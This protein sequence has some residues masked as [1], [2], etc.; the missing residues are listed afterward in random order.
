MHQK[1]LY[2]IDE[3]ALL[4]KK[5]KRLL[6]IT[7]AGISAEAG[8]PTYRGIGGVYAEDNT[9]DGY[10]IEVAVSGSMLAS[11]PEITWKYL[12]KV[13]AACRGAKPS[14]SHQILAQLESKY[15]VIILTQNVDGLH[16]VAGSRNVID[17]HG[18]FRDLLCTKC[19]E[20]NRVETYEH[21]KVPPL[22]HC[23]GR[24]RPEVVL[25]GEM[26]PI[27]K[28]TRLTMEGAKGFDMVFSIG[29]T[30]VFPYI[31]GPVLRASQ[32]NI[33]T[34]EINPDETEVSHDVRFRLQCKAGEA[35]GALMKAIG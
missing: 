23:G 33:P 31:A 10:P 24:I 19:G 20:K 7:G 18:D 21:L 12:K 34:V 35:L 27:E 2:Q 9:E 8:L 5:A 28:F 4:M 17:I 1:I 11:R 13:E 29:T 15:T 32:M 25:F 14:I 22:C 16:R 26:L 6:F 3:I 30:S